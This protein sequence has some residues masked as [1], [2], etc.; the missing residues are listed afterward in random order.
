MREACAST[1]ATFKRM[2]DKFAAQTERNPKRTSFNSESS[3][4]GHVH[5]ASASN[6]GSTAPAQSTNASHTNDGKVA[7]RHKSTTKK[8]TA[9]YL[10]SVSISSSEDP[11]DSGEDSSDPDDDDKGGGGG[12]G[13]GGSDDEHSDNSLLSAVALSYKPSKKKD[14]EVMKS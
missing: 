1:E 5:A 12:G 2:E 6:V 4:H 9:P 3:S 11:E 7:A 14:L 13:N 8:H 10:L